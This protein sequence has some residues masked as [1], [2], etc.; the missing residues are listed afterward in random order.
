MAGWTEAFL[1]EQKFPST[2]GI[3]ARET[4]ESEE[5]SKRDFRRVA[6]A[7]G[8]EVRR[9][10]TIPIMMVVT[11]VIVLIMTA[12]PSRRPRVWYMNPTLVLQ[13]EHPTPARPKKSLR[14]VSS[15]TTKPLLVVVA[16]REK[17]HPAKKPQVGAKALGL[18]FPMRLCSCLI[19]RSPSI[20]IPKN[21]ARV[22]T[23][24]T[25]EVCW[26]CCVIPVV[27]TPTP[28]MPTKQRPTAT[29]SPNLSFSLKKKCESRDKKTS[30]PPE[31]GWMTDTGAEA[32][33][34]TMKKD[35]EIS[36]SSP[37][38]HVLFSK[39]LESVLISAENCG[40][41][42]VPFRCRTATKGENKKRRGEGQDSQ[43]MS[44]GTGLVACWHGP[45]PPPGYA[46]SRPTFP[47]AAHA[48]GRDRGHDGE[49][50][51]CPAAPPDP[52]WSTRRPQALR[53]HGRFSSQAPSPSCS[54]P[55]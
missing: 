43:V 51:D 54:N 37:S 12:F 47:D 3:G 38:A 19:L 21:E 46:R 6:V 11:V 14:P 1:Q 50:H 20:R 5:G 32:R 31:T 4:R 49:P 15:P 24:L 33:A 22:S 40:R 55:A 48:G 28:T 18:D 13:I 29:H 36:Q 9:P 10:L 35:P 42:L 45:A 30:P 39:Y 34:E 7:R 23:S 17:K 16:E 41:V 25:T 27:A 52:T 44:E 8:R 26:S 2:G 53:L